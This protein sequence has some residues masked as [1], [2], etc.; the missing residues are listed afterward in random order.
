MRWAY[1][2]SCT[3]PGTGKGKGNETGVVGHGKQKEWRRQK[4]EE[5]KEVL[6][7]RE[8]KRQCKGEKKGLERR[9]SLR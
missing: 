9:R 3:G 4:E 2:L 6:E 7:E 5:N 1:V 8:K